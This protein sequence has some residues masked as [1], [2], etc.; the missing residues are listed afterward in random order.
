M[1]SI[2]RHLLLFFLFWQVVFY[3]FQTIFL[4][5]NHVQL[6]GAGFGEVLYSYWAAIPLNVS[7]ASYFTVPLLL[8]S[9]VQLF[10]KR[11][12]L[13]RASTFFVVFLLF[14]T[15]LTCLSELPIYTEWGTKLNYKALMYIKRPDEIM[16]TASIQL[17]LLALV[18]IVAVIIGFRW[19]YKKYFRYPV[20]FE[21]T[22]WKR[23][24]IYA[25]LLLPSGL[26]LL[27]LGIRGGFAQIPVNQ[28]SAYY[29]KYN[30]L[31]L[32][33]VNSVW[34]I[35]HSITQNYATSGK[36]P[37]IC[38]SPADAKKI[39]DALHAVPKD[40]TNSFLTTTRPNIMFLIMEGVSAD[41][42]PECGG[43]S[44]MTHLGQWANDGIMFTNCYASGTR[45]E[46]GMAAIFSG[47]PAQPVTSIIEQQDKFSKLP[48]IAKI[49]EQQ[50]YYT[51]FYFGGQLSYGN[52][53]SYMIYNGMDTLVDQNNFGNLPQGKLGVHEEYMINV[54]LNDIG[55]QKQPFCTSY[56]TTSTHAP[57]DLPRHVSKSWKVDE[58]G[59]YL[60]A[61]FYSDSCMNVF[62][63]RAKTQP[64][65]KNTLFIAVSDHGH[66]SH[67][68]R[69]YWS[70]EHHHIPMI[71][72]GDV[73]KPEWKGKKIDRI[74]QQH[75]LP[76]TLMAQM[77]L[78]YKD[79]VWSRNQMNPY[80]QRQFAYFSVVDGYGWTVPGA[81]VAYD[82]PSRQFYMEQFDNPARKDSINRQAQAY[83]Q[84]MFQ[85]YL[86]Y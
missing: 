24:A 81:Q 25:T 42:V 49:L 84:T 16:H 80:Y 86:D 39:V 12:F 31:N 32:A 73:I 13:P 71:F 76:A 15:A 83:L 72:F 29:S 1:K 10:V 56:F 77:N 60:Q 67:K 37:Y 66:L 41:C 30:T 26:L 65:Y 38:M 63:Q 23:S 52:I 51:G 61:C 68:K 78:P 19:L 64:W 45:S 20:T 44:I 36:N 27:V 46:Q 21:R 17:L 14:V 5:Y 4:I 82:F 2:L 3:F 35:S 53:L 79:F 18:L 9:I 34:N 43:D 8:M 75:D 48:S 28:S 40:T 59:D 58:W 33:A 7:M 74:V 62:I 55:K 47:F 6:K 70:A 69:V 54:L 57:Y 11:S 85:Q 22:S 50:G